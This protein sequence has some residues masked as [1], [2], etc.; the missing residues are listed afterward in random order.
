[1]TTAPVPPS[2][3]AASI[4]ERFTPDRVAGIETGPG[5]GVPAVAG[6]GASIGARCAGAAQPDDRSG[7]Q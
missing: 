3:T 4:A 1:L 7:C 6:R 5:P 2:T